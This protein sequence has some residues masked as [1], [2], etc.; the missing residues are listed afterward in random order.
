MQQKI[1]NPFELFKKWYD[2]AKNSEINDPNAMN[3]ATNGLD[4]FPNSR[5]VLLKNFDENGF[6]FYTNFNSQ[7]GQELKQSEK[8]ALC[9]HWKSLKKQVRIQGMVEVIDNNEAD[10]YF[11]SR[12]RLSQ[13]G[14]WVSKQSQELENREILVEQVKFYEEKFGL[15]PI[16]RPSNWSG[17]R[18]KPC[19]IEFW[20][21]EEFRLHQRL[22]FYLSGNDYKWQS[23]KLYP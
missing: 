9:F 3:L 11:A 6:V 15:K 1:K 19:S 16:P 4:G 20:Q 5:I 18:L 7:K 13:I 2:Q 12:P 23:K 21:D 22:K 10:E 17:F 8:A 14:A